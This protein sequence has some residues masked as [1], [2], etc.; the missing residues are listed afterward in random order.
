MI[1]HRAAEC[2]RAI[3]FRRVAAVAGRGRERV[4]V[5]DMAGGARRRRRRDVHSRQRESGR[6]VVPRRRREAYRRVASGAVRRRKGRPRRAAARWSFASRRHS[7]C[8]N[9]SRNFRNRSA[10]SSKRSCY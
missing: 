1:R 8:S 10:Q 4:I 2:R 5:V 3:P 7:W 9:G 6:A